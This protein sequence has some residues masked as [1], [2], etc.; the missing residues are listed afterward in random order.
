MGC[1]TGLILAGRIILWS[2]D[3][4]RVAAA[5]RPDSLGVSPCPQPV[6]HGLPQLPAGA[7]QLPCLEQGP[8]P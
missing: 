4:V 1:S 5:A 6:S 3:F 2:W 7:H 8:H